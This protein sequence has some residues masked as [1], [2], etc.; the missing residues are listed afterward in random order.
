MAVTY[1]SADVNASFAYF[2]Q[3]FDTSVDGLTLYQATN[4]ENGNAQYNDIRVGSIPLNATSYEAEK[5]TIND[6]QLVTHFDA[7]GGSKVGNINNAGSFVNFDHVRVPTSGTYTVNVRYANGTGAN[8]THA[9]S[10]NGG[11]GIT[12]TYPKTA[13]W[14]RYLWASFNV[15]LNAGV[16]SIKFSTGTSYAEI[17]QIQVFNS[18]NGGKT[19]SRS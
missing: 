14:G 15:S 8:S 3:S 6:A 10:V 9:V 17:D 11:S 13:D 12:V 5:G 1:D 2:S 18:G 4:V 16:N 7:S 19:R